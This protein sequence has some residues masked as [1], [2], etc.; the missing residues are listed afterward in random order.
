M[1]RTKQADF[2]ANL[3]DAGEIWRCGRPRRPRRVRGWRVDH[4]GKGHLCFLYSF[5]R[6][7]VGTKAAPRLGPRLSALLAYA[8]QADL[9]ALVN[10]IERIRQGTWPPTPRPPQVA[11]ILGM[12]SVS[13]FPNGRGP[14]KQYLQVETTDGPAIMAIPDPGTTYVQCWLGN[15]PYFSRRTWKCQLRKEL[16]MQ[17]N[18]ALLAPVPISFFTVIVLATSIATRFPGGLAAI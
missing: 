7:V 9:P 1:C 3:V 14:R 6:Y 17:V 5:S 16:A 2:A 15:S 11:R 12:T 13:S 4:C 8:R 18:G 10:T